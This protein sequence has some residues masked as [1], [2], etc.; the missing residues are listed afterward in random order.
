MSTERDELAKVLF[1][2]EGYFV[3]PEVV[4]ERMWRNICARIGETEWHEQAD[5]LLP[6]LTVSRKAYEQAW[7]AG[8]DAHRDEIAHQKQDPNYPL[9]RRNPYRQ[10]PSVGILEPWMHEGHNPVQHRDRRPPWCNTCGWSSPSPA[11]PPFK[12]KDTP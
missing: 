5:R 7:D 2:S 4:G 10:E 8:F 1:L 9:H 3:D 12:G 6:L 11:M